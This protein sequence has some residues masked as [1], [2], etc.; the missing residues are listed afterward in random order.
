MALARNAVR[1]RPVFA[2]ASPLLSSGLVLRAVLGR[3][4]VWVFYKVFSTVAL[5]IH[6]FYAFAPFSPDNV[7]R[8][9]EQYFKERAVF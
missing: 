9:D 8:V 2:L 5:L 4:V 6:C 3:L 7:G 1:V